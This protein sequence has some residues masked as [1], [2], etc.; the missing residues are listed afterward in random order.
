MEERTWSLSRISP[1]ISLDFSDVL[2][3][4]VE[5]GLLAEPEAEAFH[6]ADQPSLPVTH[7]GELVRK[8]VL[9]PVESGPILSFVDVHG[10]SPHNL[11]RL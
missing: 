11:R 9:I 7:R 8:P 2:G 3:Q 6:P 1:S 4:G 5:D 10:D